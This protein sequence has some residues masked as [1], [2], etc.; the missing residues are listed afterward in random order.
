MSDR[1]TQMLA[2]FASEF[3]LDEKRIEVKLGKPRK[4]WDAQDV[5]TMQVVYQSIKRGEITVDEEFAS[6]PPI[7]AGQ[8][9]QDAAEQEPAE[10]GQG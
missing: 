10:G 5:A 3:G 9:N 8:F 7:T 4:A 1:V 2:A 6:A